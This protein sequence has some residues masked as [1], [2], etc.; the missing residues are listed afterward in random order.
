[1]SGCGQIM[2]VN[3]HSDSIGATLYQEVQRR[4]GIPTSQHIL[5]QG[6]RIIRHRLSLEKQAIHHLST[7]FVLTLGN[8]G[9][10]I[11]LGNLRGGGQGMGGRSREGDRM[12]EKGHCLKHLNTLNQRVQKK[13]K[14]PATSNISY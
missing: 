4:S 9:G 14:S 10:K 6:A 1:M 8:G 2:V 3:V 7:I 12:I 13:P 11:R 5:V